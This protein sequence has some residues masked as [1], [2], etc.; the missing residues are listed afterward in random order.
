MINNYRKI[1]ALTAAAS[2]L[3]VLGCSS[4]NSSN[5]PAG[6][7][8][9]PSPAVTAISPPSSGPGA[10]PAA[11]GQLN[12]PAST[13]SAQ[14][15]A[16]SASPGQSDEDS[17][18][19]QIAGMTL[20]EKI[21]QMLLAGIDGTQLDSQAKRMIAEDEIG[22]IILYKDNISGLN[23]MVTLINGLKNS[24][25]GNPVP[26]F[27]SVDQEGG[28]VSRMPKEYADMPSSGRVGA[29]GNPDSARMFGQLL[30]REVLAAGFNMNFAP[31]LDI[32]SN[33]DN[34]VIGD[35]SF[36]S[37]AGI[38]TPLGIAEMKGISEEGVIP[39]V[40]HFPGHGDTS[41]DSHLELPVVNKS[42]ADLA[43]L[44]WLPFEAAIA[45]DADAV[46]V[47]HVLFP[48]LDPDKPASLS[49]PIISGLLREKMG[50]T[51]VVITDDLTMGAIT[52]HYTL[53]AAA[54]D[55]VLAGSDILLVAHQYENEQAVRQALL[56][57]VKDGRITEKRIDES[58]R[59][60]LTLKQ[61][62]KLS[63]AP[64]PVPDLRDLN[65]EI[66]AWQKTLS[67]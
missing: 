27:M 58:V 39:V 2:L 35:R 41:V 11:S 54:V 19:L 40:K 64:L 57:S 59:R 42:A 32:N 15:P 18:A 43:Q 53:A 66:K 5:F 65:K 34:P 51:G 10:A 20:E 46:M 4:N 26:L 6:S 67:E 55:T 9:T 44:E 7:T 25:S 8:S 21:G 45:E 3:L 23:S 14:T 24:N 48:K 37:T 63:D 17:V 50:F 31:V 12:S 56:D 13:A 61:K 28:K 36:G 60:I 49:R 33:P 47:A 52:D 22:G 16:P 38:V 1:S 30:A 29:A 62:Y